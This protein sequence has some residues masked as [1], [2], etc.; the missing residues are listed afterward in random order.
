MG[1]SKKEDYL[2]TGKERTRPAKEEP[3]LL[4]KILRRKITPRSSQRKE[5]RRGVLLTGEVSWD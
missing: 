2:A 1:G 3:N 5:E 4:L